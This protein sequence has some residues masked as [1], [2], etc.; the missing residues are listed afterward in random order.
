M[1]ESGWRSY[2]KHLSRH[3]HYQAINSRYECQKP[4]TTRPLWRL[5]SSPMLSCSSGTMESMGDFAFTVDE[6]ASWLG[7]KERALET[8][9]V[10]LAG[11]HE[12]SGSSKPSV[13]ADCD[14]NLV[15]GRITM[16][17]SGETDFEVLRRSD[18]EGVLFRPGRVSSF[19]APS[20]ESAFD[21]FL[22]GMAYPGKSLT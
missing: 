8:A 15:I 4:K 17:V 10:V 5:V 16:W 2:L 19:T 12:R 9:G 13:F 3:V 7:S 22:A 21:P 14:T 6:I 20:L 1:V 18:G 11:I